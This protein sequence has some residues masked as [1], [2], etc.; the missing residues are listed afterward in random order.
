MADSSSTLT[1]ALALVRMPRMFV[2]MK[3]AAAATSRPSA[4]SPRSFACA[5]IVA[6]ENVRAFLRT[7]IPLGRMGRDDEIADFV[8]YLVQPGAGFV[9]GAALTVD[10]GYLA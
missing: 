4:T 3:L 2:W 6:D 10:G 9:N 1:P 8:A 7:M 5:G